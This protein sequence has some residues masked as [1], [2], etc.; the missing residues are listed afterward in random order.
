MDHT[1][2]EV[3]QSLGS[4]AEGIR[5]N[6]VNLSVERWVRSIQML[7]EI[8]QQFEVKKTKK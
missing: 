8:V 7:Q 1:A 6:H 2:F 4:K 5:V 3:D